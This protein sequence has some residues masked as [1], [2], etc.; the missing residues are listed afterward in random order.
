MPRFYGAAA[1]GCRF[2]ALRRHARLRA[3]HRAVGVRELRDLELVA[4]RVQPQRVA[5]LERLLADHALVVDERA[6]DAALVAH[7]EGLAAALDRRVP[8]ADG[9]LRDDD[10]LARRVGAAGAADD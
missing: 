6:V 9:L 10:V 5:V 7:P 1:A 3:H 4:V 2:R 8:A